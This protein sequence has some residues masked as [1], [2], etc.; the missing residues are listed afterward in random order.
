MISNGSSSRYQFAKSL[1]AA[2]FRYA[3]TVQVSIGTFGRNEEQ[4]LLQ[5]LLATHS[6]SFGPLGARGGPSLMRGVV[7]GAINLVT[8]NA[9]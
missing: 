6:P 7:K 3:I 1:R 9:I 5:Y 2:N 8:T 4:M